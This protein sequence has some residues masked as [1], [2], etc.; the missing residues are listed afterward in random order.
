MLRRPPPSRP[1]PRTSARGW[2]ET[3]PRARSGAPSRARLRQR[4]EEIY[5][6]HTGQ[7]AER[8]HEDMDRDRF[9][10]AEQAVDYGLVDRIIKEREL[11]RTPS[12]FARAAAG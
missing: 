11:R 12:G 10:S 4:L 6:R 2:D 5:A 9:F 1:S 8:V 3:A 7:S